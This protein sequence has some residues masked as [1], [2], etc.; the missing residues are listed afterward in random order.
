M[1]NFFLN[2]R[3]QKSFKVIQVLV[4][5]AR[6]FPMYVRS[7]YPQ[8]VQL[9]FGLFVQSYVDWVLLHSKM[10]KTLCFK[11]ILTKFFEFFEKTDFFN[12]FKKRSKSCFGSI[13]TSNSEITSKNSW[14]FFGKFPKNI[15]FLKKLLSR[16]K[17]FFSY[18]VP[19]F[20]LA[21]PTSEKT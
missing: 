6:K 16:K 13:F 19:L 1:E 21:Y 11:W 14:V 2:L 17:E 8:N 12:F 10:L 20:I 18:S 5:D 3:Y 4:S 15:L 7:S 9:F